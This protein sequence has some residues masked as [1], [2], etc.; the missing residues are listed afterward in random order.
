MNTIPVLQKVFIGVVDS[1]EMMLM[2]KH[3]IQNV[4]VFH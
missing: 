1:N 3:F 2:I 4:Q